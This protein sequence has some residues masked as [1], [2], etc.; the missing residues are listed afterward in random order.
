MF[1]VGSALEVM[2]VDLKPILETPSS[3]TAAL[4]CRYHQ[5]G[6]DL[7]TVPAISDQN[8]A[9]DASGHQRRLQGKACSMCAC[10]LLPGH[11]D[12]SFYCRQVH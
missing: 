12:K 6:R 7:S 9:D 11:N 2:P 3:L 8:K 1:S 5:A 10:L 4:H